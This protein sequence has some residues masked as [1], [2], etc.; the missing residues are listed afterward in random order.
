MF[1]IVVSSRVH[2]TDQKGSA[3]IMPEKSDHRETS[4][5]PNREAFW[6]PREADE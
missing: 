1:G 5:W 6:I 4:L 2:L 3:V